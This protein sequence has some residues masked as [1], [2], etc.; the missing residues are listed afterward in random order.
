VAVKVRRGEEGL[1]L[2]LDQGLLVR[3]G[4]HPEDDHVQVALA[5]V[6]VERVGAGPAEEDEGL[7]AH[8]VDGILLG[9]PVDGDVRHGE[10]ELVDVLEP[11]GP[12]G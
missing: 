5:G 9:R 3:V 7:A 2:V 4:L 1:G 8:L 12:I 6:R 11:R 10:G